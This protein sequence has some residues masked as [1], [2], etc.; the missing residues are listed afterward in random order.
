MFTEN[1]MIF[2][3]NKIIHMKTPSIQI[4]TKWLSGRSTTE[5]YSYRCRSQKNSLF[6][7]SGV[8]EHKVSICRQSQEVRLSEMRI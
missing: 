5:N 7:A 8:E 6:R 3:I 4:S 2:M 1:Y